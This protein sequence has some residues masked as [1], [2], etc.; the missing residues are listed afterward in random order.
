MTIVGLSG[1]SSTAHAQTYYSTNPY[2]Y[3]YSY[4]ASTGTNY[5]YYGYGTSAYGMPPAPA[6]IFP[7]GYAGYFCPQNYVLTIRDKAYTCML[8][9]PYNSSG[10]PYNPYGYANSNPYN[11]NYGYSY[12][13]SNHNNSYRNDYGLT[14]DDSDKT[15]DGDI[16]V[17]RN[18]VS[19]WK[20]IF[21]FELTAE[22]DDIDIS[23]LPITIEFNGSEYRDM[24]DDIKL[25]V[26]GDD[27]ER[28][29]VSNHSDESTVTF[30]T[31]GDLTIDRGDTVTAYVY[32]KFKQASGNYSDGDSLRAFIDSN[33]ADDIEFDS[34]YNSNDV[35]GTAEG[36]E[37]EVDVRN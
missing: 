33:N 37:L 4:N 8:N 14:I 3:N 21:A 35:N 5:G 27:F 1:A 18:Q 9:Q 20:K 30:R 12:P 29:S 2:Q 11:Y 31:D 15:P 7:Q 34:N 25:V 19:G 36:E 23:R 22:D 16:S 32:V 13:N 28:A 26:D 10:Y 24:I 6:Q 17:N